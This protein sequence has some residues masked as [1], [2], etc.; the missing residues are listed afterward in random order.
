MHRRSLLVAASLASIPLASP[1][2]ALGQARRVLNFVPYADVASPDPI[3]SS[4]YAT[5]TSALA[6]FDTLYGV[7]ENLVAR[8]QMVEGHVVADE[9]RLWTLKLR[10]GLVFH[11]GARVLA[12]DCVASIRRWGARDAFGQ[13]L[14][15]ATEELSAPDDRTIVFR[16]RRPFPALPDALAPTE[17][18]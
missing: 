15:A 2:I 3:W 7:D 14:L 16:L 10:D 11:D 13:Q 6:I 1:R 4:T 5:R 8:P 9:G 18:R 17:S 12:R